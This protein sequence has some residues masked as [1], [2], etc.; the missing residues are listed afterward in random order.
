[1]EGMEQ[2]SEGRGVRARRDGREEGRG[3]ITCLCAAWRACLSVCL[4]Q[5]LPAALCRV[6]SRSLCL[7]FYVHV[8]IVLF[9]SEASQCFAR[10]G[11][12]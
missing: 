8:M 12:L 11:M 10:E 1:M 5:L 6:V 4:P 3:W 2:G 7:S 9:L